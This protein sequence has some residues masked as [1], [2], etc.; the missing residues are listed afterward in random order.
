MLIA[1]WPLIWNRKDSKTTELEP[2]DRFWILVSKTYPYYRQNWT[3]FGDN[4]VL[5]M[6]ES[7]TKNQNFLTS[8]SRDIWSTRSQPSAQ[9]NF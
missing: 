2:V 9:N 3:K 1:A 6:L 8:S 5:L 7:S 4:N